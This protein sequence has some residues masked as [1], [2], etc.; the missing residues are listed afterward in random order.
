MQ[1]LQVTEKGKKPQ[2]QVESKE[3]AYTVD[4]SLSPEVEQKDE[5]II[6]E[7]FNSKEEYEVVLS[8]SDGELFKNQKTSP[9]A[10]VNKFYPEIQSMEKEYSSE[11]WNTAYENILETL[12]EEATSIEYE[13]RITL[14]R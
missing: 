11:L 12:Q 4:Q 14:L 3:R 6:M 8:S 7:S 13:K 2:L 1:Q 5:Y 9:P 10:T